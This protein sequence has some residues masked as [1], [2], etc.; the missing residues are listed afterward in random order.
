[1]SLK[2]TVDALSMPPRLI[3][4]PSLANYVQLLQDKV[5]LGSFVNSAIVSTATTVLSMLL[6]AP[7]AYGLARASYRGR[8]LLGFWVL[9]TR[10]A[11]PIAFGIPFF[12]IYSSAGLIDTRLGLV[13]IYLTFNLS[14]VVWMMRSFFEAMPR[15]LEDASLIDGANLIQAFTRVTLPLSAPG[16]AA[17]AILCFLFS[18][19]DFFYALILT[20]QNAMTAPVAIVGFMN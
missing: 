4:V 20:R 10:M 17:T 19:N 11:P 14:L 16:L 7:A 8:G 9:V 6:G 18:W 1:M 15:S 5:F 12:L 13:L 2:T 3:F